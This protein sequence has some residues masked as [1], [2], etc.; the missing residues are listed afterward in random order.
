M[1]LF[2]CLFVSVCLFVCLCALFVCVFVCVF[3]CVSVC[4]CLCVF[5]YGGGIYILHGFTTP[6]SPEPS[7][8]LSPVQRHRPIGYYQ[9]YDPY[10][11]VV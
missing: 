6:V 11:N 4:V 1:C 9:K 7:S 3:L 2:V 10:R 5:E 8:P